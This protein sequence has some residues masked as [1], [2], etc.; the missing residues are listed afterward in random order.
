MKIP[1]RFPNP[2]LGWQEPQLARPVSPSL[3]PLISTSKLEVLSTRRYKTLQPIYISP[4]GHKQVKSVFIP[5]GS[6]QAVCVLGAHSH[7]LSRRHHPLV[8][9]S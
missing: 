2:T 1:L 8:P 7:S 5:Y 9:Q 3:I 6:S 4:E